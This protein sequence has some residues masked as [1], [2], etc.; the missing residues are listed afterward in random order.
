MPKT[1]I[2]NIRYEWIGF[3]KIW[4]NW[5]NFFQSDPIRSIFQTLQSDQVNPIRSIQSNLFLVQFDQVFLWVGPTQLVTFIPKLVRKHALG[6]FERW[7]LNWNIIEV[8][9]N[10]ISRVAKQISKENRRSWKLVD[11]YIFIYNSWCPLMALTHS[12]GGRFYL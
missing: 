4:F 12:T 3:N 6:F 1:E 2:G 5:I 11:R 10:V 9:L 7:K 8:I